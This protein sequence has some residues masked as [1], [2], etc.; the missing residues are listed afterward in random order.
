MKSRYQSFRRT[1]DSIAKKLPFI[2]D[3]FFDLVVR[4]KRAVKAVFYTDN[5]FVDLGFEYVGPI[6][7]H[8]IQL[9]EDVLKDVR[10]LDRPVVVHVI[11]QKGKGYGFAENDPGTYHGVSSFSATEGLA[12]KD[13]SKGNIIFPS[14]TAMGNATMNI[15]PMTFTEAFS[16]A[17]LSAAERDS[18][19]IGITAAM[20][21]GT[22]LSPFKTAFPKRFFDVGI[23]EEHAVTFAAGLASQ[24]LRPVTAVYS[25]FIQ[26][27]IDQVI[28]DVAIQNLPVI[29]ALDRAGF[30]C[31]DGETHQ[32]L[33][34]ISLFRTIPNMTILSPSG[35]GELKLMLD[36]ALGESH[37]VMIRYPKKVCPPENNAFSEPLEQGR[38]VFVREWGGNVCIAF[39]GSL[40][41]EVWSAAEMLL[42][43][44]I[45]C[46]LY[47]LRFLKPVDEQY[48][49]D[50]M[51]RY[52]IV[53]FIE[54]GVLEGGFGEY[55]SELA[56]RRH[57][58]ALIYTLGVSA[59]SYVAQGKRDELLCGVGLDAE[60]IYSSIL[61][62]YAVADRMAG[63]DA[64]RALVSNR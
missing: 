55:A 3:L 35:G 12:A 50:I 6:E 10:S 30:V 16:K 41:P 8:N 56:A 42:V 57:C 29:F 60:G 63:L 5:F 17:M 15:K 51:N 2:G 43:S 46:D 31:D 48:L 39:T 38:G 18:R 11:T 62:F 40:F 44:D 26:R 21:R 23:A 58:K 64:L 47:N 25:T 4:L 45:S 1:F 13:E 32:G 14:N 9:L 20:E 22:G 7:G 24:G 33:Y 28:H 54:E 37:P 36:W 53:V 19:V 61:Q 59:D 34:D 49:A 52:E 27:S